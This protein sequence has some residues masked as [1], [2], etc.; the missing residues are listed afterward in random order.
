MPDQTQPPANRSDEQDTR[1][2]GSSVRIGRLEHRL[3][4]IDRRFEGVDQRLDRVADELGV[5]AKLMRSNAELWKLVLDR[6]TN[7]R[8]LLALVAGVISLAAISSGATVSLGEAISIGARHALPAIVAP[9]DEPATAAPTSPRRVPAEAL[10][11]RRVPAD[12]E[13]RGYRIDAPADEP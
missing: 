7:P 1:H 2:C 8:V 4:V 9:L 10:D 5:I 3:D 13:R 6:V 11:P 12:P